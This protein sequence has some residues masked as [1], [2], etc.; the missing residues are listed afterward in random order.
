MPEPVG[1]RRL[2]LAFIAPG[3]S[4]HTRRWVEHF[5]AAGHDVFLVSYG[6]L[7]ERPPG[8]ARVLELDRLSSRGRGISRYVAFALAAWRTR[9]D[10]RRFVPDIVHAHFL[11][12]PGWLGLIAGSRPLV[13]TAWGSDVLVDTRRPYVRLLHRLALARATCVTCDA[14]AVAIRLAE[15]SPHVDIEKI[16]WGVDLD[17]FS[18]GAAD[19]AL[20]D[21]LA[22]PVERF[23]V[24]AIRGLRELQNPLVILQAFARLRALGHDAVLALKL[25]PHEQDVPHGVAEEARRLGVTDDV[26][27]VPQLPHERLVD[28]YRLSD[29]CVSV[30][31]SDGTS[32]ALLEVMATGRPVVVSDIPA[33]REWVTDSSSGL[34]VPPGDAAALAGALVRLVGSPDER[35]AYGSAARGRVEAGASAEGQMLLAEAL[36]RSVAGANRSPRA[37]GRD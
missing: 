31:S 5:T 36:Y 17:W 30:P 28:L 25:G 22:L 34:V 37:V 4:I 10:V 2:R 27:F 9:R 29:V 18:P 24:L 12:G 13:L 16:G 6:P 11:T 19:H 33:N 14:E 1:Q 26:R 32:V 8:V 35:A 21:E 15:L 3:N 23:V 20:R 7:L